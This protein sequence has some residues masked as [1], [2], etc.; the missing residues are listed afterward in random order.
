MRN[1]LDFLIR[2][3]SWILFIIYVVLSCVLLFNNNPYQHHI[4]LTSANK[5]ATMIYSGSNSVTSYFHLKD[6]NEDLIQR[7]ANL[8]LEVISLQNQLR[9]VTDSLFA[10]SIILCPKM[11]Q[12]DF[13]I[14]HVI[15]NSITRPHNYITINKGKKDGIKPEMGVLDQNGIVGVVNIVGEN[16]SRIISVLNPDLQLSCKIKNSDNFGSLVWDGKKIDEAILKDLPRH[17]IVSEGDTIVT[18]EYSG[19]FPEGIPVGIV[20]GKSNDSEDD[21]YALRLK[22]LTDFAKL[23][24]VKIIENVSK[25]EIRSIEK[26]QI[27]NK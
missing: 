25:D 8:E 1:L 12:Y 3:S 19:I 4:Y 2:Y 27:N 18:S 14:A 7:N 24:T 13:K 26:D 11:R 23:G 16:N 17:A 5:I 22:L 10:D 21:F 9:N 6:I 20:T 15:N